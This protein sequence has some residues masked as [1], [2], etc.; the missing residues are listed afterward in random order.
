[1]RTDVT[2]FVV[3]AQHDFMHPDGALYVKGSEEI[4]ENIQKMVKLSKELGWRRVFTKDSHRSDTE[5]WDVN[6]G[7]FP[8]HC[9]AD[10]AGS[11][12]VPEIWNNDAVPCDGLFG[13]N[14]VNIWE[15]EEFRDWF[16][17]IL[18]E[19]PRQT[20]VV[21]GVASDYCVKA[22]VAGLLERGVSVVVPLDCTRGVGGEF[23]P[24]WFDEEAR[25]GLLVAVD[26]FGLEAFR[27]WSSFSDWWITNDEDEAIA[28]KIESFILESVEAHGK[29]GVVIGLSG[30]IDST[31]V[32]LASK[33]ALQGKKEVHGLYLPTTGYP[34]DEMSRAKSIAGICCNFFSKFSLGTT[35]KT[36]T[37]ALRTPTP[38][39]T[40]AD[41]EELNKFDAGNMVSRIRANFLHTYAAKHNLLVAGT[42]NNDEDFGVGYYTLFGDGA[43]HMSPIGGLSK[44]MVYHMVRFY[45]AK[46]LASGLKPHEFA[47][48]TEAYTATPTAGLEPGQTDFSDLGYSYQF[49]EYVIEEMMH[50]Y[51]HFS[52]DGKPSYRFSCVYLWLAKRQF[53]EDL[54]RAKSLKLVPKF[55]KFED[56]VADVEARHKIA[57]NK[58]EI[59]HPPVCS[60]AKLSGT[61]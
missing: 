27:A 30:G 49:A 32:A 39:T 41:V 1:M 2:L 5:E 35:V 56:A 6:G 57:K 23:D 46:L 10:S 18:K 40:S 42:G 54:K 29:N 55:R 43:V 24:S 37:K 4:I 31:L 15:S 22:A 3:D 11:A 14:T 59:L 34:K 48:I 61:I 38:Y 9:A 28:E 52:T 13:K 20:A 21:V 19:R 44:R 53:E 7:P 50:R 17:A 12:I 58:Q 25:S 45:S 33:F 26:T 51:R 8:V 60:L 16:E 47:S 36:M